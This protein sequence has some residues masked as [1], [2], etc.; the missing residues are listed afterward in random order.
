ML[1]SEQDPAEEHVDRLAVHLRLEVA[2]ETLRVAAAG[3]VEHHIEPP[4]RV[5][6]ELHSCANLG[7]IGHVGV[8]EPRVPAEF[9]SDPLAAVVLDVSED[10]AR[11]FRCEQPRT[12]GAD[13]AGR[14]GD[15]GHLPFESPG[16]VSCLHCMIRKPRPCGSDPCQ[17]RTARWKSSVSSRV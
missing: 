17:A 1:D 14:S 4:K 10:D 7:V 8:D 13:A 15:D 5:D 9:V 12:L 2:D 16:H 11:A 3:V 6:G